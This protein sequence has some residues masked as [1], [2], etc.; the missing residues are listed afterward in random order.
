MCFQV[1]TGHSAIAQYTAA[2]LLAIWGYSRVV[3]KSAA[4]SRMQAECFLKSSECSA[5][6]RCTF[7]MFCVFA[8]QTFAVLHIRLRV[9]RIGAVWYDLCDL[10]RFVRSCTS[11]MIWDAPGLFLGCSWDASGL[12]WGCS[13]ETLFHRWEVGRSGKHRKSGQIA[14]PKG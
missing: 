2:V 3:L 5:L 13:G 14:S 10:A 8:F 4:R 11:C 9:C 7:S 1:F 12:F 6:S